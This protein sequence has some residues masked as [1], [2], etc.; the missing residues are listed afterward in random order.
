M[1]EIVANTTQ[2]AIK[3][4]NK[5]RLDHKNEWVFLNVNLNGLNFRFK[6][7]NTWIQ[8]AET[9]DGRRGSSGMDIQV[10]Q[11]KSFLQK[12]FEY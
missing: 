9:P 12:V 3:Q 4:I 8:I 2:D 11:F 6:F 10:N 5:F 1:N 7:Y